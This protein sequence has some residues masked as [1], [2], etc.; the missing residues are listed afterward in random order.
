MRAIT[1]IL[2]LVGTAAVAMPATPA[3]AGVTLCDGKVA[4]VIGTPGDDIL[5]G[6]AE[7][8]VIAGLGGDDAVL[9]GAGDDVICGGRGADRLFGEDGNDTVFAGRA[10]RVDDRF[11]PDL[12][13]GGPD[14]DHLDIGREKASLGTGI[15][16]VV[17]FGTATDGVVV[18]LA[19]RSA[20]G[21][22]N[23]TVIPRPGLKLNGTA[24]DDVLSGS[25]F[26]EAIRG[27]GGS[28]TI[29]GRA[30][31]DR[32]Q[33]D[34][35][36]ATTGGT[37]DDRINGGAG[38]D[39]VIG[40]IGADALRGG[41]GVDLVDA[42]G[43]G[44]SRVLGGDGNDSLR[45]F[46]GTAPGVGIFG[47]AG[48]DGVVIDAFGLVEIRMRGGAV[49]VDGSR[50]GSIDTE[51]VSMA[52]RA[53]LDYYGDNGPDEVSAGAHARLRAWTRG[54]N[55]VVRGSDEPDHVDAGRGTDEVRARAGRDICLGAE[56]RSS[57]EVTTR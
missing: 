40:T 42:Q 14:D 38:N 37:D 27:Y 45:V 55:D 47:Q 54:G 50:I 46:V 24:D 23:D 43:H 32:L 28:D 3:A 17:R 16:G 1:I 51:R 48:R 13:D 8:D 41:P 2:T 36:T 4:T 53:A 29:K 26:A 44:S 49:S 34:D 52:V 15:S 35:I 10:G 19:E 21:D 9:A 25:D 30:G 39:V 11:R 6:T 7:G 18:D 12:L 57:C 31:D 20:V 33:G 5:R 56:R 22:G